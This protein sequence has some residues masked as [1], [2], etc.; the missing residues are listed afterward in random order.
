VTSRPATSYVPQSAD[1][2]RE[3]EK[4]LFDLYRKAGPLGRLRKTAALCRSARH[5]AQQALRARFPS[6]SED[7]LRL[8]LAAMV[9]PRQ[10]V[11]ELW[12]W[13]PPPEECLRP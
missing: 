1:T 7:E 2:C 6:A 13:A 8:R 3:A 9:L 5:L 10:L 12:G 11:E 4:I